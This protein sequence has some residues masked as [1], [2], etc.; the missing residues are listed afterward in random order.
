MEPQVDGVVALREALAEASRCVLR[1]L[2]EKLMIYALGR[3]LQ[4]YDMP[5]VRGIVAKAQREEQPVLGI[6]DGH[7]EERAVP[8]ASEERARWRRPSV[9]ARAEVADAPAGP[10]SGKVGRVLSDPAVLAAGVDACS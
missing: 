7:R 2:T 4:H 3:G 5:V 6:R 9:R 10:R 8:D 1:T